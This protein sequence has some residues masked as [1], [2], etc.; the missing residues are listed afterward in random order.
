MPK[1]KAPKVLEPAWPKD[2]PG[3]Y[4]GGADPSDPKGI[5]HPP[6]KELKGDVLK[7][8]EELKVASKERTEAA[9]DRVS[10]KEPHPHLLCLEVDEFAIFFVC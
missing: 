1:A 7:L 4:S 8:R 9:T 10:R 5:P 3:P 2:I 6:L